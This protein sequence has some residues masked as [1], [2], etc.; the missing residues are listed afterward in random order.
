MQAVWPSALS[1]SS[2]LLLSEELAT[3]VIG[4]GFGADDDLVDLGLG[5]FDAALEGFI[6]GSF[7]AVEIGDVSFEFELESGSAIDGSFELSAG[8]VGGV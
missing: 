6:L 7:F 4:V 8:A 2:G 1:A 5:G 3:V